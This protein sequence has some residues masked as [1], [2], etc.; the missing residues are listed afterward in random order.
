MVQ[1]LAL[2]EGHRSFDSIGFPNKHSLVVSF[3]C[4]RSM[5]MVSI[6]PDTFVVAYLNEE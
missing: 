6:A 5:P 4:L 1:Y 3:A 2:Y